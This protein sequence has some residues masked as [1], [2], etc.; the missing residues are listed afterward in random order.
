[1]SNVR[2]GRRPGD[3]QE[4]QDLRQ[5]LYLSQVEE[6]VKRE[7][8]QTEGP[9]TKDQI[10]EIEYRQAMY[11]PREQTD[12]MVHVVEEE[13]DNTRGTLV[14]YRWPPEIS[15]QEVPPELAQFQDKEQLI[16]SIYA[17]GTVMT[18]AKRNRNGHQKYEQRL[19]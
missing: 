2:E 16:A 5:A 7:I 3:Q 18:E 11:S 12:T 10:Q 8:Q 1:M 9:M 13:V 17:F 19:R 6:D 14:F 15:W 4:G